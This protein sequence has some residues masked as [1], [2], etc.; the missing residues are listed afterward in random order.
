MLWT[1]SIT[2]S[3]ITRGSIE[4][5]EGR[6]T[7]TTQQRTKNKRKAKSGGGRARALSSGLGVGLQ[8]G[9]KQGSREVRNGKVAEGKERVGAT[10]PERR[11]KSTL[12]GMTVVKKN[13]STMAYST[14]AAAKCAGDQAGW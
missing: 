5:E 1:S 6:G 13:C 14:D 8:K 10:G 2:S 11:S 9:R 7:H 4:A 3:N 12:K